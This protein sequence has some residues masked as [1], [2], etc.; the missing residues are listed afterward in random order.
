MVNKRHENGPIPGTNLIEYPFLLR[1]NVLIR[2]WL[3]RDLVKN[4]VAR[5]E[6]FLQ[7]LVTV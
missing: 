7:S 2:I 1:P 5:L 4:D 6:R 3:P